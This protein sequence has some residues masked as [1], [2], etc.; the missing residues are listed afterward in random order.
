MQIVQQKT[1]SD[2]VGFAESSSYL[3]NRETLL[4]M[5]SW[6]VEGIMMTNVTDVCNLYEQF[7]NEQ[8]NPKCT[9]CIV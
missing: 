3:G 5:R 9:A 8:M 4:L 6:K 7:K 1:K 2:V